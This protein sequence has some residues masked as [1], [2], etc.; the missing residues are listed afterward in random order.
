MSVSK[1]NFYKKNGYCVLNLFK[2]KDI[3]IIKE[4]IIAKLNDLSKKSTFNFKNRKLEKYDQL[5][6]NNQLHKKLMNPDKRHINLP[7][8]L[9]KKI[10]NKNVLYIIKQEWGHTFCSASWIGNA[11]K[12][13]V[14]SNSTGFRIARPVKNKKNN[15]ASGAH[16]DVNAGGKIRSDFLAQLTMWIPVIGFSSKYTLRLSPKSQKY[17][18]NKKLK[19]KSRLTPIFPKNYEKK[20]KFIR[21]N[22]KL[23]QALLLHPNLL[24]GSSSNIGSF[25]R[26]SLDTRI[27]NLKR[28]KI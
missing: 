23:G 20:F 27:L 16:V 9:I 17:L 21:P 12:K 2:K 15:D 14:K 26:V 24:H 19:K 1:Y 8:N 11:Y 28:F 13:Q 22:L 6:N 10:L 7:K 4:K 5:I 3:S 25:S 18:H